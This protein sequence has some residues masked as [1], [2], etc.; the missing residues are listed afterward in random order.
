MGSSE[1]GGVTREGPGEAGDT[2]PLNS[3]ESPSVQVVSLPTVT[4][5]LSLQ[6]FQPSCLQAEGINSTMKTWS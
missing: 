3:V 4:E 2:K 6:W 1:L 5:P